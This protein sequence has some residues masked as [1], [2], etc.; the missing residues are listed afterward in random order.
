MVAWRSISPMHTG[1]LVALLVGG[2]LVAMVV[3][4]D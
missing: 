4:E 3:A 2:A 1:P